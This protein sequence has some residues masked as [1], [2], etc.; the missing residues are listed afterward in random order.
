MNPELKVDLPATLLLT[1]VI[2]CGLAWWGHPY[3][4]FVWAVFFSWNW[5]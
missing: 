3:A 2:G 5:A 4:I 1:A